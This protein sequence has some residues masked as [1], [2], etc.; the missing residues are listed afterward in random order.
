MVS[1]PSASRADGRETPRR[2]LSPT[3]VRLVNSSRET[4][5][6]RA[7]PSFAP[8]PPTARAAC[9]RD[10]APSHAGHRNHV[11]LILIHADLTVIEKYTTERTANSSRGA[12]VAH[13]PSSLLALLQ[14]GFG[15]H[16]TAIVEG[17]PAMHLPCDRT[18]H[19]ARYRLERRRRFRNSSSA[20]IATANGAMKSHMPRAIGAVPKTRFPSA[21]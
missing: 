3:A 7:K 4:A 6:S 14:S 20:S 2:L 13:M 5:G 21:V 19:Y 10:L 18:P 12:V 8:L 17:F 11:H 9:R 1:P 16:V 15:V